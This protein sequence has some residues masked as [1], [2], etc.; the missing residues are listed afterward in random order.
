MGAAKKPAGQ[1]QDRDPPTGP[2]HHLTAVG[3]HPTRGL[4]LYTR[5]VQVAANRDFE[6]RYHLEM[7]NIGFM[8][9]GHDS[10]G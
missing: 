6:I 2:M 8:I 4:N 10:H 3:P 9:T 5:H 1:D 7:L